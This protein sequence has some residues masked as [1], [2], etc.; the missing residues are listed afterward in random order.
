MRLV[1]ICVA[2]IAGISTM[3]DQNWQFLTRYAMPVLLAIVFY[4]L[5][6]M[7]LKYHATR[8][9]S[10]QSQSHFNRAGHHPLWRRRMWSYCRKIMLQ[11]RYLA[12]MLLV[13]ILALCYAAHALEQRLAQRFLG[14]AEQSQLVYIEQIDQVNAQLGL[15]QQVAVVLLPNQPAQKWLLRFKAQGQPA[16]QLGQYYRVSGEVREAHGYAVAGVFD[17]ERWFLQQN[18][19]AQMRV[20]QIQAIQHTADRHRVL[21][22]QQQLSIWQPWLL[23][24]EQ[25]RLDFRSYIAAQHYAQAGLVLGLLTGD[26]SLL[27]SDTET[28]FKNLGLSHLLAISGPHVLLAAMLCCWLLRKI[29]EYFVPRIYLRYARPSLMWLPFLACVVLYC[30]FVGFEIPALRTLLTTVLCSSLFLLQQNLARLKVLLL[31]A[32]SLLILDPFSILATSFWLSYVSCFILLGLYQTMLQHPY[33]IFNLWWRIYHLSVLFIRG[34]LKIYIALIPLLLFIFQ[35][36]SILA[37]FANV[38][39]IPILGSVVLPL[40]ILAA[41]SYLISQTVAAFFFDLSHQ[42]LQLALRLLQ[43]LNTLYSD[44]LL[45]F[46]MTPLQMLLLSITVLIIFLPRG[47]VPRA[48]SLVTALALCFAQ[49]GDQQIFQLTVLDVGQGQAIFLRHADSQF[50]IDMGG[51]VVYAGQ[52]QQS[53][54]NTSA[55]SSTAVAERILL[56]FMMQ[57]G[58]KSVE[59]VIM[60]HLDQDHMIGWQGMAAQLDIKKVMANQ[61]DPVFKGVD[62]DYCHAGQHWQY[63]DLSVRVLSPAVEQLAQV[64]Q[65]KNELSC[66]L[67]IQYTG[68]KPYQNFLLMG[69]A[70]WQTEYQLLQHYPDLKVDVLVLGHHGSRQSSAYDFLAHYKPKMLIASAGFANRY[71]HPHAQVEARAKALGI[72]MWSSIEQGSIEFAVNASRPHHMTLQARRMRYR[73]LQRER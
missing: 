15:I 63:G 21:Q 24:I 55:A 71:G 59:R 66:V 8:A 32:S 17:L 6:L 1:A 56:P 27:S 28:L 44:P 64:A 4:L 14:V 70:G 23:A 41:L 39:A 26:Q 34:Q 3:G 65:H 68:V 5:F 72:A 46:A 25:Q 33:V 67:Y 58:S 36:V 31:S 53:V 50:W 51:P 57:Q 43:R 73:W 16:L 69:D 40:L 11:S 37:L 12:D 9:A 38:I 52:A 42:I 20:K 29:I 45:W 13:F 10:A 62:F 30:A 54:S 18:I 22:H 48:W 7:A 19:M 35:Q 61:Y 60:S 49:R 47:I 2:W